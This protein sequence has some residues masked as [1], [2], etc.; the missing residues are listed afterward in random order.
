MTA[1]DHPFEDAFHGVRGRRER[2]REC[3][4]DLEATIAAPTPGREKEWKRAL[5]ESLGQL[6]SAF[7]RHVT[8]TESAG[9]F[10][11]QVAT[12]APRLQHAV[13]RLRDDHVEVTAEIGRV[14]ERVSSSADDE[15]ATTELR[16][17]SLELLG[18]LARHRH[19]GSDLIY[20]AYQVDIGDAD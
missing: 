15:D 20:E 1:S 9:G 16:T 7:D 14:I 6:R 19:S 17:A 11:D 4:D 13:K 10:L 12:D 5:A 2:L 18:R 8:E 3:M